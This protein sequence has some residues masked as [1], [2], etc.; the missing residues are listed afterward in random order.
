MK[1]V[2]YGLFLIVFSFSAYAANY[3]SVDGRA[4]RV[5]T[6]QEESLPKLVNYLIKPYEKSEE[7][8]ARVL[9][10]WIVYHIDFD[11]YKAEKIQEGATRR[12][13]RKNRV[14]SGDV[15]ETR[16]GVCADIAALYQRMAGLAGLDS[17][18]IQG[19]AGSYVTRNNMS[20]NRHAWNAVKIDGDWELVDPTWAMRGDVSAFQEVGS[21]VEHAREIDKRLTNTTKTNKTRDNRHVDDRWFMP[22]PSEMIKT[23]YPDDETWQLLPVSKSLGSFLK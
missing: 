4:Q 1:K 20:E 11:D 19:Y 23:H 16:I 13:Q 22:K 18:V 3:R 17:V 14:S 9:L 6:A 21:K 8:K 7:M 10:A 2:L 12:S 5:L 15:F